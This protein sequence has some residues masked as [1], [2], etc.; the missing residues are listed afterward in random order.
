MNEATIRSVLNSI[1][2]PCSVAAGAPAGLIDMGLVREVSMIRGS[3]GHDIRIVLCVTEPGC[4]MGGSFAE[5]AR[6]R[7]SALDG[8][9]D[10]RVALDGTVDWD[11]RH[12][13]R[14]YRER[15]AAARRGTVLTARDRT[16]RNSMQYQAILR[17][18]PFARV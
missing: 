11:P 15:L 17:Y 13:T 6:I 12:M 7:L 18:R 8:V 5:E 1:I 14:D 10:V 3:R 4:V 2:D 9:G 16:S